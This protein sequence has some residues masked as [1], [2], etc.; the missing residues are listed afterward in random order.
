[1]VLGRSTVMALLFDG[2]VGLME[3]LAM[4][5]RKANLQPRCSAASAL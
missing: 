1:M 2:R 3:I 4:R 5:M